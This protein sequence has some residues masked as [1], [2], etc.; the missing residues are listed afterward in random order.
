MIFPKK[1]SYGSTES[2]LPA[3]DARKNNFRVC[4][5]SNADSD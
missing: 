1:S 4:C 3:Q 2:P 5:R